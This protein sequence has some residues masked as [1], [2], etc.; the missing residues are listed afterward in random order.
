MICPIIYIAMFIRA[1]LVVLDL[2]IWHLTDGRKEMEQ[3]VYRKIGHSIERPSYFFFI[4]GHYWGAATICACMVAWIEI[5]S[6]FKSESNNKIA[7]SKNQ[8]TLFLNSTQYLFY[9]WLKLG[10]I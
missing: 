2:L 7:Y 10:P 4:F 6:Q 5:Q 8:L 1:S 9:W 3:F